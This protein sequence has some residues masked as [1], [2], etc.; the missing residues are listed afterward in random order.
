METAV[1]LPGFE[2]EIDK[3]G[4]PSVEVEFQGSSLKVDIKAE[5]DNDQL[6][7]EVDEEPHGD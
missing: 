4:P 5:W 7:V 2:T 3:T 6:E 1:P